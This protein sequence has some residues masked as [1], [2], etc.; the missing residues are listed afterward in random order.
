LWQ[1]RRKKNQSKGILG[2]LGG[3]GGYQGPKMGP[4]SV[5]GRPREAR[6]TDQSIIGILKK[7]MK[8]EK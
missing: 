6:R 4:Y 1:K 7:G 3:P 8:R 5:P 2:V